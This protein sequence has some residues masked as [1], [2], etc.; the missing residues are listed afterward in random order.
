M[1]P[2]KLLLSSVVFLV[3]VSFIFVGSVGASSELWSRTYGGT[4]DDVVSSIGATSDGGYIIT[5]YTESFGASEK[6][7]WLVKTD[8]CGNMVW[9][10]TYG[11]PN[12]D[13]GESVQQTSD[14]GYIVAGYTGWLEELPYDKSDPFYIIP[15]N[16]P[17][18]FHFDAYV[19]KTDADGNLM[20]NRTYS[21]EGDDYGHSVEQTVD[22]GYVITGYTR[23]F[24]IAGGDSDDF[25]VW[26]F[27]I[28]GEG[29]VEW[30][31]TYGGG[32]GESVQQTSDG[33]YVIGGYTNDFLLI[34]TDPDGYMTWNKT[35]DIGREDTAFS[36]IQTSDEGYLVAGTTRSFP[37]RVHDG[38]VVKTGPDGDMEWNRTYG[39]SERDSF[40]SVQQIS[41]GGY[42]IAGSTRSFGRGAW[43]VKTNADGN[44][45]WNCTFSDEE[46]GS[47]ASVVETS[48]GGYVV[49]GST[50]SI[51]A[52]KS[53]FWLLKVDYAAP[54]I[55][56][57]SP[58][59]GS[60]PVGDV[61]LNFA[62]SEPLA[63]TGYSLDGQENV[64]IAGNTTLSGLSTESHQLTVYA[65]DTAENM[66]AS[67]TI[68][69]TIT[70]ENETEPPP[71][72]TWTT[73]ATLITIVA[74]A[75]AIVAFA[76]YF[77]KT[78]KPTQKD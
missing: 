22:G 65:N 49:A 34:K 54:Q 67:E 14:G 76:L 31:R 10:R 15:A 27:K 7:V 44:V 68:S 37:E 24:G 78:R 63:W 74:A 35:Y 46:H 59:N 57:L 47:A 41:D 73:T 64:T 52:G 58:V 43:L 50:S 33:G 29:D 17:H 42:I 69:F 21:S 11:G 55:T 6:D 5:G 39:G 60:Y 16:R 23:A 8:N 53:D 38:W 66:G 12:S 32:C 70:E 36:V 4:E 28:D 25:D 13:Y 75:A 56:V 18:E 61:A 1:L 72:T 19:V 77:T 40:R 26:L 71:A 3:L 30:S 48:G 45:S 51:G 62:I 9:N 20:W 2:K